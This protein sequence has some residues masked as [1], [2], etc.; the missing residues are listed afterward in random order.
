[1]STCYPTFR[2]L[3]LLR[4]FVGDDAG[5]APESILSCLAS[6][7]FQGSVGAANRGLRGPS[8]LVRRPD[9][10]TTMRVTVKTYKTNAH[11]PLYQVARDDGVVP[12]GEVAVMMPKPTKRSSSSTPGAR[13]TSPN[14]RSAEKLYAIDRRVRRANCLRGVLL[15]VFS[16]ACCGHLGCSLRRPYRLPCV[17][18]HRLP[19][20]VCVCFGLTVR[21]GL[22]SSTPS[23]DP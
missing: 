12:L 6:A 7:Q 10:A 13:P 16:A 17:R 22:T 18:G 9:T 20:A 19:R 21:I 14:L 3:Q 11:R 8:T 1:V 2:L 4:Y 5:W 15:R 23:P